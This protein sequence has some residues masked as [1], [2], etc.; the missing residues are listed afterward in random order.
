MK[1]ARTPQQKASMLRQGHARDGQQVTHTG[2]T[3]LPGAHCPRTKRVISLF[4][5]T[6]LSHTK[7]KVP[8][9]EFAKT[10]SLHRGLDDS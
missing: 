10:H 4:M 6:K 3:G 1:I 7:K 5:H 9:I 8:E 2:A